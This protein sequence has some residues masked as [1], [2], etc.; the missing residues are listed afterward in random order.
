LALDLDFRAA[1]AAAASQAL[2]ALGGSHLELTA[3]LSAVLAT[4][5]SIAAHAQVLVTVHAGRVGG[6]HAEQAAASLDRASDVAEAAAEAVLEVGL[7][8]SAGVRFVSLNLAADLDLRAA[9]A[10]ACGQAVTTPGGA[11]GVLLDG[12]VA[13]LGGSSQGVA[14][15][16][17]NFLVIQASRV[18]RN[19]AAQAA[20]SLDASAHIRKAI[21]RRAAQLFNLIH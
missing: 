3:D 5:Q 20:P 2:T 21:K 14:T 6:N 19:Q 16:T 11:G 10:Q 12:L 15:T 18:F 7:E 1:G 4:I 13:V 17:A 9:R 8:A